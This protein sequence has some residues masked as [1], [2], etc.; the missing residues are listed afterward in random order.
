MTLRPLLC[1]VLLGLGGL[2]PF[3]APTQAVA[4]SVDIDYSVS[5]R[6]FPVGKAEYRAEIGDDR[7]YRVSFSARVS[8]LLRL[9]SDGRTSA[10]A[11][12]VLGP[13]RPRAETYSHV[14]VEDDDTETVTMRFARRGVVDINLDPPHKHPERYV[15]I[16]ARHKANAVDLVSAVLWPTS[17]GL[18]PELCRRA[19][20]LIDGHRRFNII[21]SFKEMTSFA[22]GNGSVHRKAVVCSMDYRAISG[23]RRGKPDGFLRPDGNME[24]WLV[25]AGDGLAVPVRVE[26]ASKVGR[27]GLKA[28]RLEVN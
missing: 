5:I 13:V 8:G 14:W 24:V 16:T 15:P 20:P 7:R 17:S 4:R 10:E 28:T 25:E 26:L 23:H 1:A 18:S 12:G 21:F 11:A 6:G 9:F 27:V 22:T 3:F 2:G 19:L